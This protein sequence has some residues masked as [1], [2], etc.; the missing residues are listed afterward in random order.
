MND[1]CLDRNEGYSLVFINIRQTYEDAKTLCARLGGK[2]AMNMNVKQFQ[3]E[4][5]Q[6]NKSLG[7]YL[8]S[9][10][11]WYPIVHGRMISEEN[12]EWLDDR[13]GSTLDH[14]DWYQGEPNGMRFEKC[15]AGR[16][17][18]PLIGKH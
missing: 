17:G 4:I 12:F 7:R 15:A 18:Y 2:M 9:G 14:V 5:K 3:D 11:I 6:S 13:D 10:Y 8:S 16:L 1:V